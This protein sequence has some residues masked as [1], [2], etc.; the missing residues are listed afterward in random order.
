MAG[1]WNVSTETEVLSIRLNLEIG[2]GYK[3]SIFFLNDK[4]WLANR[5]GKIEVKMPYL[6]AMKNC[7]QK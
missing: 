7:A 3:Y 2:H 5:L 6:I 4:C 1:W